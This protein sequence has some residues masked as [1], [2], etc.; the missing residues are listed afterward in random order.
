MFEY[1]GGLDAFRRLA[2]AHHRRCLD[3]PVLNHPFSH[4]ANPDHVEH[5]A[6]YWAEVFGG[7]RT[8]SDT[9]G[10]HTAMLQLHAGEGGGEELGQ[11]FAACF[12][13]AMEEAGLPPEPR[14]RAAMARYINAAVAEVNSYAPVDAAVE[15][16]LPMPHWGWNGP[17]PS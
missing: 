7:P 5:L 1:A 17:E 3:D 9:C 8:F 6:L 2:A 14:F 12:V 4:V 10:G 13:A 16:N 11:R 15:P